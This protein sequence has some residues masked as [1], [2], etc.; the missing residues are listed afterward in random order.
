[1][2]PLAGVVNACTGDDVYSG[3]NGQAPDVRYN[4]RFRY[5]GCFL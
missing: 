5:C 1:M 4:G 2:C 3:K